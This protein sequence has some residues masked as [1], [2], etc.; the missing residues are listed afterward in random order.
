MTEA[1]KEI[2]IGAPPAT[3]FPFLVD[4]EKFVQWMG[5]EV[6]LDP[7]PGGEFY[8][9]CAG[10]RPAVGVFSEV[11]ANQRVVFSFGWDLPGHPIPAGSSEVEITLTPRGDSTLVRLVHRGLPDDAI[12]DHVRGWTFYLDRLT[13]VLSG[14]DPG[15]DSE[16]SN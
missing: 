15:P 1:I 6:R 4:P 12:S 16:E 5:S 3:I 7:V 11:V 13:V 9:L 8:A 14:Q 2:V 10:V